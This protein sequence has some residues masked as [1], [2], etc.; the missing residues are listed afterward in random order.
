MSLKTFFSNSLLDSGPDAQLR[1][2][3]QQ[4]TSQWVVLPVIAVLSLNASSV[5][6]DDTAS[7]LALRVVAD[8][9][10]FVA[11]WGIFTLLGVIVT[12]VFREYGLSRKFALSAMYAITEMSRTT[13]GYL[14]TI[15]MGIPEDPDWAFRLSAAAMTGLVFF[16]IA[17]TLVNDAR[18]YRD[19]YGQLVAVRLRLEAMLESSQSALAATRD[20]MVARIREQLERALRSSLDESTRDNPRLSLMTESIFQAVDGV[21]RPVSHALIARPMSVE[22]EIPSLAP[23]R[24]KLRAVFNEATRDQPI[25]PFAYTLLTVL[26]TAPTVIFKTDFTSVV[27]SY[28]LATLVI[29][30]I[31]QVSK[32]VLSAPLWSLPLVLRIV[33]VTAVYGFSTT[34]YTLIFAADTINEPSRGPLLFIYGV[35]L[36]TVVG[37]LLA[38]ITGMHRAREAMLD[39]L[40]VKNSEL[41]WHN[42]RLQSELWAEQKRLAMNLHNNVQG[43]LLA[44]ALKLRVAT[45]ANLSEEKLS[46]VRDLVQKAMEFEFSAQ[47]AASLNEV[48]ES[49]SNS[50]AE[51]ISLTPQIP[52]NVATAI[53]SDSVLVHTLG[54]VLSEFT[55]NAVK[56]GRAHHI[57]V[58]MQLLG[59]QRVALVMRNDGASRVV[60]AREGMGFALMNSVA[61]ESSIL[62]TDTGFAVR[63]VL[64]IAVEPSSQV[65]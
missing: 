38:L 52:S 30:T 47:A 63:L 42:A 62:D 23:A 17:S 10:A 64:P 25:K 41:E 34:C 1:F 16:G 45:E 5:T 22:E 14:V 9:C 8:I 28:L 46:D 35:G 27:V 15:G 7:I 33:I 3:G 12:R 51:L 36:G 56:H 44:A 40:S 55:T 43:M 18:I 29:F 57:H 49:W 19:S 26:L 11:A 21:V 54:D 6:A 60:D 20:R 53:D 39:E 32:V 37:W 61:I 31:L 2:A 24:I 4:A 58:D 65:A 48:F 13:T 50:W 59:D